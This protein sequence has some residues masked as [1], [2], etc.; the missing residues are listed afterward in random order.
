VLMHVLVR[1]P[2]EKDATPVDV[3]LNVLERLALCYDRSGATI[4][5]LLRSDPGEF[6][7]LGAIPVSSRTWPSGS[8]PRLA[9]RVPRRRRVTVTGFDSA[10]TPPAVRYACR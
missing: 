1:S 10:I 7:R 4:T 6:A 9:F 8:H 5:A 2:G 3:R